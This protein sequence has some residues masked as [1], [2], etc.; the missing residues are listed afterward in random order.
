M[1]VE[2]KTYIIRAT[3]WAVSIV[4]VAWPLHLVRLE[5]GD[6]AYIAISAATLGGCYWLG[7][8]VTKRMEAANQMKHE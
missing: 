6:M 7:R 2:T 8:I 4:I 1:T 3:L 5:M